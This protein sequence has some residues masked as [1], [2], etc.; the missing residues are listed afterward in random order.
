MVTAFILTGMVVAAGLLA[1]W[2]DIT[3]RRWGRRRASLLGLRPR[4]TAALITSATGSI[5]AAISIAAVLFAAPPVREVVLR[6]EHLITANR[7][8][9]VRLAAD[10][11]NYSRQVGALRQQYTDS[12]AQTAVAT[13]QLGAANQRLAQRQSQ[14]RQMEQTASRLT[15]RNAQLASANAALTV[16]KN[17]LDML[18]AKLRGVQAALNVRVARQQV[19]NKELGKQSLDLTRDNSALETRNAALLQTNAGLQAGNRTLTSQ[20]LALTAQRTS[21]SHDNV[22]LERANR[23]MLAGNNDLNRQIEQLRRKRD[24]ALSQFYELDKTASLLSTG[25][26]VLRAGDELARCTVPDHSSPDEV[27]Q[28][29]MDLLVNASIVAREHHAAIGSNGRAVEIISKNFA[30]QAG[31]RLVN[32]QGSLDLLTERLAA[33]DKP[34][35]V[36][37]NVV[38]NTLSNEQ[39]IVDLTLHEVNPGDVFHKGDVVA[40]TRINAHQPASKVV[41]SILSFLQVDVKNAA[42]GVGMIPRRDPDTNQEEIGTLGPAQLTDLAMRVL[43]VGGMVRLQAVAARSMRAADPLSLDFIVG[44]APGGKAAP[45]ALG[46]PTAPNVQ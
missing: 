12:V 39:A 4:H 24:N 31:Y 38:I 45:P 25:D 13:Q 23:Q 34:I 7:R 22:A 10:N 33:A 5:I 46:P 1:W 43:K 35:V 36:Q 19:N 32:E 40:W 3:G 9:N 27:R 2:G 18:V 44:R 14:V 30:S 15:D 37:A 28:K 41:D 26:V 8:L 20:N 17:G 42:V 16:R 11:A 21:L 6:G 29:L